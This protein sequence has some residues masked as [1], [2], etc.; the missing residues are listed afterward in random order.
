VLTPN[1]GAW[2][3]L[4]SLATRRE[5]GEHLGRLADG[6]AYPA[7]RPEVVANIRVALPPTFE[8]VLRF[9]QLVRPLYEKSTQNRTQSRTLGQIR[10][11]L[12]PKLISGELR[13]PDPERI[14]GGQM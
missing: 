12:L 4:Y 10:D 7:V 3:F 8:P 14:L 6:G 13:L 1:H 5:I 9:E 2:A 11:A